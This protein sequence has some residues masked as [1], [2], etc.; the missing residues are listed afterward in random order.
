MSTRI[1]K[2]EVTPALLALVRNT[3]PR[4]KAEILGR[5]AFACAT[6]QKRSIA[7][8][9]QYDGQPMKSPAKETKYGGRFAKRYNWRYREG[10]RLM[11]EEEKVDAYNAKVLGKNFQ[12]IQHSS[13]R[14]K[15]GRVKFR[16]QVRRRIPVTPES[17]QLQDTGATIKSID[18]LSANAQV[19][20]VGPKTGHG[21]LILSVHD[22]TR[23]PLGMS[24]EWKQKAKETAMAEIMK[25][26]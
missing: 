5:L 3:S 14:T 2:D 26:V 21:Q 1:G 9:L 8:E 7:A 15:R 10:Y 4:R 19:A 24:E 16:H 13:Y 23:H 25:G 11:T 18:I 22:S 17:K 12:K 6:Q 20:R